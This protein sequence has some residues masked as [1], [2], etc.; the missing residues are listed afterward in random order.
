MLA[1]ILKVK[2]LKNIKDSASSHLELI[3]LIACLSLLTGCSSLSGPDYVRPDSPVKTQ[4]SETKPGKGQAIEKDWWKN[5]GDPYLDGLVAKTIADNIDIKVLAARIGLA[6]DTISQV[7]AGRLPVVDAAFGG[8]FRKRSGGSFGT[9][10]GLATALNWEI[11]IWGKLKKGVEAQEAEYKATEADWRAGYLTIVSAV[12]ST[13]FQIRQLDEQINQQQGA[14]EKNQKILS[15]LQALYA[16]GML[17][18]TTVLQQS[19]EVNRLNRELLELNR[20]R[21]ITENTLATLQGI[22]AGD[23]SVSPGKLSDLINLVDVPAG[24]PSDLLDRRPDIV[25]A[26]YRVIRAHDFAGQAKLALLPTV[27]LTGQG[28]NTSVELT[29]VL[30]AWSYGFS[31][32]IDLPFLDPGV[33][34]RIDVTKAQAELSKEEYR[35]TVIKAFEEVENALVNLAN[36]KQQRTE[37][38]ERLEKLRRV[39]Q[40]ISAQLEE[41][42]VSQLEVF[43]SERSL[44]AAELALLQNH[45]QILADTVGLYKALGGGWPKEN[46]A[47]AS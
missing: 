30:K 17:A 45:Q 41:G 33:H 7:N 24:L 14:L 1:K 37:L 9:S 32:S 15:I 21:K 20:F 12:A 31:P 35:S 19:A 34:A 40:Q 42:I 10:Y 6:E 27:S 13:Y 18:N 2:L 23:F 38:Q 36:H 44:L 4:W 25:A 16:E 3:G 26:E 5:F 43:E 47:D 29:D 8:D 22:P 11:D 28:G 46:F 39:S